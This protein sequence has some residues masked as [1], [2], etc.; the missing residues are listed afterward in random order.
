MRSIC[1][2]TIPKYTKNLRYSAMWTSLKVNITF[3]TLLWNYSTTWGLIPLEH[4]DTSPILNDTFLLLISE[5]AGQSTWEG[6]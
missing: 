6:K 3:T 1:Y 4:P 5:G 2:N